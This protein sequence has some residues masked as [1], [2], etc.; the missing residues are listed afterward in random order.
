MS[1]S[2]AG[3]VRAHEPFKGNLVL[4]RDLVACLYINPFNQSGD[5]EKAPAEKPGQID[6]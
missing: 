6:I 1:D 2:S 5:D 3:L 4:D